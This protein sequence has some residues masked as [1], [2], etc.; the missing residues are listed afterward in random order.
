MT[1]C[2][3]YCNLLLVNV[4][5]DFHVLCERSMNIYIYAKI[6]KEQNV[7]QMK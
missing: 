2:V 4:R 6:M 7:L 5:S 3:M 1:A